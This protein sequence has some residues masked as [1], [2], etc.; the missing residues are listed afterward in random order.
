MSS[1]SGIIIK[2]SNMFSDEDIK[3]LLAIDKWQFKEITTLDKAISVEFEGIGIVFQNNYCMV[4]GPDIGY[5]CSFIPEQASKLNDRLQSIS[6]TREVLCFINKGTSSTYGWNLFKNGKL[7]RMQCESDGEKL[8][9]YGDKTVYETLSNF[10]EAALFQI[11]NSF[12]KSNIFNMI[13][14][15]KEI[16]KVLLQFDI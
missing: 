14:N 3:N 6:K 10:D 8:S 1:F 4:F 7:I 15:D 11:L 9:N 16:I 13:E 5:S 2:D 12:I